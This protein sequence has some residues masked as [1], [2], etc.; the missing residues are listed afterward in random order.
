M[1]TRRPDG[2]TE[3]RD[4]RHARS[5]NLTF[6]V[7]SPVAPRTNRTQT[8][9]KAT[10]A[11]PRSSTS[12]NPTWNASSSATATRSGTTSRSAPGC[13]TSGASST[14]CRR[15]R[16]DTQVN[17]SRPGARPG[18]AR[19]AA[20]SQ[21]PVFDSG[22]SQMLVAVIACLACNILLGQGGMP[23]F[24][25]VVCPVPAC[26]HAGSAD[27]VAVDQRLRE[28]ERERRRGAAHAK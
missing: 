8:P 3:F 4:I 23:S 1:R 26:W 14:P 22:L 17:S 10:P 11:R 20:A 27:A 6:R 2:N 21:R 9:Q 13:P 16:R 28:R 5:C 12:G 19:D 18:P 7:T 15:G 24:G 25:H